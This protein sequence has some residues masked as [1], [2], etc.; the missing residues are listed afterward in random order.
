[1]K[2]HVHELANASD[3]GYQSNHRTEALSRK[4]SVQELNLKSWES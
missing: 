1:M 3:D 2:L 4:D